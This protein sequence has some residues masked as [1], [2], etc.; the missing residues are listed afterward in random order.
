MKRRRR[1]T[2]CRVNAGE[3]T[4]SLAVP[5]T[6]DRRAPRVAW[7]TQDGRPHFG[8]SVKASRSHLSVI[9]RPVST[10]QRMRTRPLVQQLP[11]TAISGRVNQVLTG[12]RPRAL[13]RCEYHIFVA[14]QLTQL[15]TPSNWT[16][17]QLHSPGIDKMSAGEGKYVD[18]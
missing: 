5:R 9:D 4:C 16:S 7:L 13:F 10:N 11:L 14:A 18:R 2:W 3:V 8:G 17:L 15:S 12:R 6:A 1:A